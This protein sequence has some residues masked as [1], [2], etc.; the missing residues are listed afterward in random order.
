MWRNPATQSNVEVLRQRGITVL[1]VGRGELACG[2]MGEGRL[3]DV[4][5]IMD[6]VERAL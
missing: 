2:T 6:A 1:D 5:V 3:A 4:D